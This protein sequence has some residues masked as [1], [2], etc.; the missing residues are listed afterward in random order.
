MLVVIYVDYLAAVGVGGHLC[1]LSCC[2]WGWFSSMVHVLW[3]EPFAALSGQTQKTILA[4]QIPW[5]YR[6][7]ERAF[8]PY[9]ANKCYLV[10]E[11]FGR[12]G[13][14]LQWWKGEQIEKTRKMLNSSPNSHPGGGG[15]RH[16]EW[17]CYVF[18]VAVFLLI[19]MVLFHQRQFSHV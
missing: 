7:L 8:R 19:A 18:C 17:S 12:C 3:K 9:P 6:P 5:L 1:R 10:L 4:F 2:C 16:L 15:P 13:E 14:S 11:A